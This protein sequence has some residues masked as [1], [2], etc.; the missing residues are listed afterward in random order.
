M[1]DPDGRE[2]EL[3][4]G[5]LIGRLWSAALF[6]NDG[7][8]S[9]A[10]A[11][12]SLREGQLQLVGLRGAFAVGGKPVA[13]AVLEPGLEIQLARGVALMVIEVELPEAVLGL[14]GEGLVRQAL[15]GV[16]SLVRDP[17]LRLVRGYRDGALQHLW[18]TGET[19]MCRRPGGPARGVSAGAQLQLDA[20]TEVSVVSI[21][22]RAASPTPTRRAGAVDAPLHVVARY[23]TVHI[24]REGSPSV[25]LSGKQA[26]LVSELVAAEVPLSWQVL[27]GELWPDEE[28]LSLRRGRMDVILSRIRR[29][30]RARG[31][32]S[33]LVRTDGAGMVELLLYPHDQVEDRS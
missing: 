17:G 30:L 23:D 9:E 21:P 26:R 6:L 5:D 32:R 4:H 33:D 24:H 16:C 29:K 20:D 15:P 18:S 27:S 28:D 25:A 31:F 12:V 2:H 13:H 11:M 3:V 10:H 7:R 22:L 8:V 1:R 19:W 14:E